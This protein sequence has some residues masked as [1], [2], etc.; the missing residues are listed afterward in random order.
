M[1]FVSLPT[2]VSFSCH[3][4]SSSTFYYIFG[5][6]FWWVVI[7]VISFCPHLSWSSSIYNQLHHRLHHLLSSPPS[8]SPSSSTFD[9]NFCNT[10][11]YKH[12]LLRNES[13]RETSSWGR[14]LLWIGLHIIL[15]TELLVIYLDRYLCT[16]RYF[17]IFSVA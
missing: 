16:F 6:S 4:I 14:S 11:F 9:T 7:F 10:D 5:I 8:S 12:V 17:N 2:F 3:P 15:L 1:W 13:S